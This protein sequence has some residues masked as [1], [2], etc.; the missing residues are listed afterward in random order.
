MT[1]LGTLVRLEIQLDNSQKTIR[2]QEEIKSSLKK[3]LLEIKFERLQLDENE[4]ELSDNDL[5]KQHAILLREEQTIFRQIKN[6]DAQIRLSK[7]EYSE[8]Q[9]EI[10]KFPSSPAPGLSR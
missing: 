4:D 2:E 10:D 6:C 1:N 9:T 5:I 7:E 8:T 3:R